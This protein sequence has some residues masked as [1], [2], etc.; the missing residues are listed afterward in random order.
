MALTKVNSGKLRDSFDRMKQIQVKAEE[1]KQSGQVINSE[2]LDI[3]TASLDELE[4]KTEE[5][6]KSIPKKK[7]SEETI[8]EVNNHFDGL[9]NAMNDCAATIDSLNEGLSGHVSVSNMSKSADTISKGYDNILKDAVKTTTGS[10]S[11]IFIEALARNKFGDK[12]YDSASAIKNGASTAISG[13]DSLMGVGKTFGGDWHDPKTDAEKIAKGIAQIQ[14]AV[15]DIT[16]VANDVFKAATGKKDG[17]V[18]LGKANLKNNIAANTTRN[19]A[20]TAA[21]GIGSIAAFKAGDVS[22]GLRGIGATTSGLK[23]VATGLM[24]W[25]VKKDKEGIATGVTPPV[26]Q[27]NVND[28]LNESGGRVEPFRQALGSQSTP[29]NNEGNNYSSGSI[30]GKGTNALGTGGAANSVG[31]EDYGADMINEVSVIIDGAASSDI[32]CCIINGVKYKCSSYTITQEM[33]NPMILSFVIEK[34]D[35]EETQQDVVFADATNTIGKTLD[36]NA[37]TIKTSSQDGN[38]QK[39]FVFSGMIIDVSASRVTASAQSAYITAAT[40][41]CLLQTAPHYRSFEN[42]SLDEIV[43]KVLEPYKEIKAVIKPRM[44]KRIPYVVQYNQS[45]YAFLRMLAIRFGEWMYSTGEKFVFGDMEKIGETAEMEYPGGSLLSYHLSQHL[46]PFAFNHLLEDHYKY[47]TPSDILRR[48]GM[49]VADDDVNEWTDRAYRASH[50]RYTNQ[51]LE[52]LATG[53]FD[54]WKSE[55]GMKGIMD[56]SLKIEAEGKKTGL[57]TVQGSSKLAMLKIAQPMLICDSVQNRS[58]ENQDVKQKVLRIISINH[59]FD[60]HQEYNNTF[61]AIPLRCEYPAYSDPSA[62]PVAPLQ[63]ARVTDNEDKQRLGRIRVQFPWQGIQ[64]KEMKTPWLRIVTP[65]TGGEKGHLFV[66]EIGEEVI[67]GF[68]MDNAERPYIIGALY[69]GGSGK[70]DERWAAVNNEKGTKNNI[71]AIRTRGGHTILFNDRGDKGFLEIY[72]NKNNTYH[73]TLSADEKKITIDSAGDIEINADGS[74]TMNAKENV[75]MHAN[76]EVIIQA[77]KVKVR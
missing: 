73:I 7:I 72:D 54:D 24:A 15:T 70:P 74:I 6:G 65:Y 47:G 11:T 57:M 36:L 39:A 16:Q 63:R 35:K 32:S 17:S 58:G 67:V 44:K 27:E 37:T 77:S 49:N 51:R 38:V 5:S 56:Y 52:A 30:A 66:P 71:K 64:D 42:L 21:L 55:E 68:E 2:S 3:I 8:K 13:V 14:T 75:S 10:D 34:Y 43:M 12:V 40:W 19:L 22:G 53:G 69:N 28:I 62:H 9:N 25:K 60:Y 45:D 31:N 61:S 46:S 48:P 1:L 76:M 59:S 23:E 4:K 18:L 20:G 41:D 33:L 29:S 50:K 26:G